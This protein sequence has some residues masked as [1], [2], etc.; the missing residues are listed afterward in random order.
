M[1]PSHSLN[2]N[3]KIVLATIGM[4]L[5]TASSLQAAVI[6]D[7]QLAGEGCASTSSNKLRLIV[8]SQ[9]LYSVPLNLNLTKSEDKMIERHAC[10]AAI[11]VHL[12]NGEKLVVEDAAQKI[13]VR[14]S[15]QT[16][17]KAQLE[18]FLAG[19]KGDIVT[20]E[21]EAQ[22]TSVKASLKLS[23]AGQVLQSGCGEDV[24]LRANESIA[25]IGSGRASAISDNLRV[26][27]KIV[28]C[29]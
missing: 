4:T 9:S 22:E 23:K 21:T 18:I 24:I 5:A 10:T 29:E 15:S 25:V 28:K 27:I 7:V 1:K 12:E 19:Q 11:P 26:K 13:N 20:G 6:G 14:L 3:I 16:S 8:P 17:A 2:R